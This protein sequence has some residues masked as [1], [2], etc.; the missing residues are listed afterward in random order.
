MKGYTLSYFTLKKGVL[1]IILCFFASFHLVAQSDKWMV[2]RYTTEHGLAHNTVYQ[3]SQDS[4]GYMWIG[5]DDGLCR[6]DGTKFTTFT[7][8]DGLSSNYITD[9]LNVG[10][11]SFLIATWKGGIN[12]LAHG[13]IRTLNEKNVG[14]NINN[15]AI[16]QKVSL[17]WNNNNIMICDEMGGNC[18]S[19]T[20]Y[21]INK[22]FKYL[23]YGLRGVKIESV[24]GNQYT[25]TDQDK[26]YIYGGFS[27]IS[28]WVNDSTFKPV[29][30]SYTKSEKIYFCQQEENHITWLGA[31]GKIMKISPDGSFQTFQKNLPPYSIWDIQRLDENRIVFMTGHDNLENRNLYI[32]NLNTAQIVSLK[33]LTQLQT[34][35]AYLFVDKNHNIWVSTDGEGLILLQEKPFK[36]LDS[37]HGFANPF[38]SAICE[39]DLSTIWLGTKDGLYYIKHDRVVHKNLPTP[40]LERHVKFITNLHQNGLLVSSSSVFHLQGNQTKI[41]YDDTQLLT[42]QNSSFQIKEL[43]VFKKDTLLLNYHNLCRLFTLNGNL[44]SKNLYKLDL[45]LIPSAFSIVE[46]KVWISTQKGIYIWDNYQYLDTLTQK[47]GLPHNFVHD[48]L[49][50]GSGEVW[51]AT[52]QGLCYWKDNK[53]QA[54]YTKDDG[55]ISNKCRKLLLDRNGYLWIATPKG[56]SRFDGELFI[57]FF[58][59]NGLLSNDV[60]TLFLD[61]ENHLWVGGSKGLTKIDL[62]H[63]SLKK[64][65]PFIQL[66]RFEINHQVKP[67]VNQITLPYQSDVNFQFSVLELYNGDQVNMQY[68]INNRDWRPLKKNSIELLLAQNGVYTI[69]VKAKRIDGDWSKPLLLQF[70]VATPFWKNTFFIVVT[71]LGSLVFL[72]LLILNQQQKQRRL[73]LE[74]LELEKLKEVDQLKSQFFENISHEFRTPLTLI[75]GPLSKAIQ[76][77]TDEQAKKLLLM[78][79]HHGRE[80]LDLINQLLALSKL[81]AQQMAINYQTKDIIFDLKVIISAFETAAEQKNIQF[82]S[83]SEFDKLV[84]SFDLD[85]LRIILN[86][87]LSNAIKFTPEGEQISVIIRHPVDNTRYPNLEKELCIEISDTGIGIAPKDLTHLFDRFYQVDSSFTKEHQ[88]TGIGLALVK[89]LVELHQGRIEV[90]SE[91]GMGTNFRIFLPIKRVSTE[92]HQP[93]DSQVYAPPINRDPVILTETTNSN[94]SKNLP[95]ILIVEDNIHMRSFIHMVIAETQQYNIIEA[96]NGEEGLKLATEQLPDLL[97]SDVM[98]PKMN[99]MEMCNQLKIDERTSHIPIIL[100]TAKANQGSKLEG[101]KIGADDY[102]PKPFDEDE[103]LIRVSN[104]LAQRERMRK[105]YAK[106]ITSLEPT[107]I[108]IESADEEFLN[109]CIQIIEKNMSNSD[110]N[111]GTFVTEIGMSRSLLHKKLKALTDQSTTEF[112]RAIRL[113]RAVQ[114]MRQQAGTI[115]EICY[116]V[117]F[118]DPKYFRTCFSKLYGMTPSEYIKSLKE[119]NT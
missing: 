51:I 118:N 18:N 39:D 17:F 75:L 100:L 37:S 27:G 92:S 9:I 115:S 28:E 103:L 15:M 82:N 59:G 54:I 119:Q 10:P 3:I 22:R 113:K 41:V 1:V 108:S 4:I 11:D 34:T 70:T 73:E 84:M 110:F 13:E 24:Q 79:Q 44:W 23:P 114:L 77:V 40:A 33:S 61:S 78:S 69:Q 97:I 58:E 57:S 104:L 71:L 20:S 111:V 45:D 105:K 94:L 53:V 32:Y 65:S 19:Y 96:A 48:I 21:K 66:D 6:F 112:I 107:E 117:G 35:L 95:Q 14:L 25:L 8:D 38:I 87:L 47:N 31:K 76:S 88:G 60:N 36:Y 80:L 2:K 72:Y 26:I 62:I 43:L 68:K 91:V 52:E 67:F 109:N 99:G 46:N 89:E 30:E 106:S 42:K 86:N 64:T 55:L 98:M 101:L 49:P 93:T 50:T 102:L 16:G 7:T 90:K 74:R 83:Q 12:T 29:F 85:K 63:D 116:D 56:L 5:T 81:E